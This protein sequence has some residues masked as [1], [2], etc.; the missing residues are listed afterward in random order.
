[1]AL[2]E[3]LTPQFHQDLIDGESSDKHPNEIAKFAQK[4]YGS[5][6]QERISNEVQGKYVLAGHVQQLVQKLQR[7]PF[8]GII[9]PVCASLQSKAVNKQT[10]ERDVAPFMNS[11]QR[12]DFAVFMKRVRDSQAQHAAT[13]E[14]ARTHLEGKKGLLV[15]SARITHFCCI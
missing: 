14:Q 9:V 13:V 12:K 7:S 2:I 8:F 1:L 10:Y 15:V 3:N 5:I 4:K 6:V 11:N